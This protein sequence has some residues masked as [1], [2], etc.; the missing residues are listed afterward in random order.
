VQACF[1]QAYFLQAYFLRVPGK[2]MKPPLLLPLLLSL[3]RAVCRQAHIITGN[4]GS[5]EVSNAQEFLRHASCFRRRFTQL[6]RTAC[7]MHAASCSSGD[8]SLQRVHAAPVAYMSLFA[9]ARHG[10]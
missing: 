4:Q 1:L 3:L 7:N 10:D 5:R 8:K 2:L 9:A 6:S